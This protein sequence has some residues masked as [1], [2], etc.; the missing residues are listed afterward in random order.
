[1]LAIS[2]H[3]YYQIHKC[4][5]RSHTAANALIVCDRV[6]IINCSVGVTSI[7][8]LIRL[9]LSIRT[10]AEDGNLLLAACQVFTVVHNCRQTS[11]NIGLNAIF[12]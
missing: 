10:F 11:G 1:M 12:Q 8:E 7:I 3:C 4:S 5:A 9:Q 2:S 6:K